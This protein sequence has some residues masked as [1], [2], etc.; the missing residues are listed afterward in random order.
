MLKIT[1]GKGRLHDRMGS[2][3]SQPLSP[4]QLPQTWLLTSCHAAAAGKEGVHLGLGPP[5]PE[6]GEQAETA[7]WPNFLPDPSQVRWSHSLASH[8]LEVW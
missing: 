2:L 3:L 8:A 6:S 4:W 1:P 7:R 5:T